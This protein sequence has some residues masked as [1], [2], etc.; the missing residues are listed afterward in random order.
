V[1]EHRRVFLRDGA[2]RSRA[3]WPRPGLLHHALWAHARRACT[4]EVRGSTPL[5]F[6]HHLQGHRVRGIATV[7]RVNGIECRRP[8]C[9]HRPPPRR[10]VS[11]AGPVRAQYRPCA[12][13]VEVEDSSVWGRLALGPAN[14]SRTSG[15]VL[16]APFVRRV[17]CTGR[18]RVPSARCRRRD[19]PPEQ[20]PR[21][22]ATH[23]ASSVT[24][25][26]RPR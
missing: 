1:D 2:K 19:E 14:P 12:G 3:E 18:H 11:L 4:A 20:L 23:E 25:D 5:R 22:E 8:W 26:H 6:T 9:L 15:S 13:T 10:V 24:R 17:L 7:P 16:L 21:S